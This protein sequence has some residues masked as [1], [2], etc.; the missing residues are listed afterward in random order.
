MNKEIQYQLKLA[1]GNIV[2]RKIKSKIGLPIDDF[3]IKVL[4]REGFKNYACF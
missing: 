3:K 4:E 2:Q 1:N